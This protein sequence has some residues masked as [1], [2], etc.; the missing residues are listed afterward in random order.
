MSTHADQNSTAVTLPPL[1]A[2]ESN[3]FG[4]EE[5]T[6]AFVAETSRLE[7]VEDACFDSVR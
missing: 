6:K 5:C 2:A 3:D 7:D 1:G 4:L